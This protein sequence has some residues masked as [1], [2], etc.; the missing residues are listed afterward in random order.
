MSYTI[1]LIALECFHAQELDGDEIYIKLDAGKVWQSLPDRMNHVLDDTGQ[2]SEY[3]FV[4]GRK[5]TSEGWLP[6][7]LYKPDDFIYADQSS[8]AVLQL[9]D[10][11]ILTSDDLLGQTP[12]DA[13]QAAGGN[14]SVVFQHNGAHYRLT[15]RVEV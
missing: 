11:D 6:L 15:Y 13:A 2:V 12:V 4:G 1:K 14:I 7:T 10:A 8:G 9:W 3:D 5:Q